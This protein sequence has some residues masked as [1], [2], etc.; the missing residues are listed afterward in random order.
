MVERLLERFGDLPTPEE[1]A[2]AA[3][4]EQGLLAPTRQMRAARELEP[5]SADEGFAALER[6]TFEREEGRGRPGVFVAAAALAQAGWEHVLAGCDPDAPYLVFDWRPDAA[7]DALA[8][9][10][11]RLSTVV[12][13]PIATG[14]CSHGG[15]PPVC[16]CRPPLPG[17]PLAFAR[18]YD[19]EPARSVLL[20]TS[21]AH[22][23]L[24]AT[25]GARFVSVPE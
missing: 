25:L 15:G 9:E 22:R 16:W 2:A 1:L 8:A 17:L 13:A 18:T 12:G 14:I 4:R 7:A 23:T 21:A 5:P 19:V 10:A 3:K 11:Q 6:A 24:A 20:G